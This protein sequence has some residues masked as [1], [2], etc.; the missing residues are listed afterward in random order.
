LKALICYSGG[1]QRLDVLAKAVCQGLAT[2]G[3]TA[4]TL[5]V[6]STTTPKSMAIYDLVIFGSPVL[7]FLGGKVEKNI[8][9]FISRSTRLEGKKVAAFVSSGLGA[10]KSLTALMKV[11]EKQGAIVM[12]FRSLNGEREA[13]AFGSRLRI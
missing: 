7:G 6:G 5:E 12:D 4:E 3:C 2:V 10:S 8:S 11:I 13:T 9:D 1:N